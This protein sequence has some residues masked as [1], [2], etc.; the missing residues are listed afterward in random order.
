MQ[1]VIEGRRDQAGETQG[2]AVMWGPWGACEK[3][4]GDDLTV[5]SFPPPLPQL[6]DTGEDTGDL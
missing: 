6:L 4:S 1:A 3:G 5:G 2:L